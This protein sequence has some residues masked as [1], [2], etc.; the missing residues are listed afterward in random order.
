MI[1]LSGYPC[2]SAARSRIVRLY[3]R[4]DDLDASRRKLLADFPTRLQS[5]PADPEA[6]KQFLAAARQSAKDPARTSADF[7]VIQRRVLQ[8]T[9]AVLASVQ[10]HGSS[11]TL[12]PLTKQL[13]DTR[14]QR[15][16]LRTTLHDQCD[17]A[18]AQLQDQL[19][20]K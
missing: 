8:Q 9:D 14:A 20:N 3:A 12:A 1:I 4:L 7:T 10:S 17:H 19:G 6:K 5:A 11:A 15:D 13:S 16:T 18:M 2:V